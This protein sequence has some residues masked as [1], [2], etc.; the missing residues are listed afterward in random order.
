[1]RFTQLKYPKMHNFKDLKVWQKARIL[2]TNIYSLTKA[3]PKEEMFGLTNQMRRAAV[4]IPSN[5][6]EGCGRG[7]NR[8]L[9]Q[10]LDI[11]QGSSTELE[12]QTILAFD[13][14]FISENQKEE[15]CQ[16]INEVQKMIRGFKRTLNV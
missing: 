15:H 14:G 10:Y 1:M 2:V 16:K 7:T 11:A 12:T 6:A 8:Q 9:A 13:L 5:I 4:S 3:F